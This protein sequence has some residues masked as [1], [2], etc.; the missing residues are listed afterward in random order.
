MDDIDCRYPDP[1]HGL[2]EITGT[3]IAERARAQSGVTTRQVFWKQC[4]SPAHVP[5]RCG[6]ILSKE[7]A[8]SG[9]PQGAPALGEVGEHG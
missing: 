2:E 7:L 6:G 8:G 3:M 1:I 9:P 4:R 5:G